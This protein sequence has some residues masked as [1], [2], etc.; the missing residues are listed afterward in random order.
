MN[1]KTIGEILKDKQQLTINTVNSQKDINN[2]VNS[3]PVKEEY[4][5][6]EK[7][8]DDLLTE[9]NGNPKYIA[10]R[11]A[12]ELDDLKSEYYYFLLAS[13]NEAQRLLEALSCTQTAAREGKIRTKKAI[14][15]IGILNIWG[16]VTKFKK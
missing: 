14:Y 11:L 15:F 1:M 2:T 9:L 6:I 5:E 7:K 10:N 16:F 8:T 3:I 12:R 4:K 13:H